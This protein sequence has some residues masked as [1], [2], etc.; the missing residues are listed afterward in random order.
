MSFDELLA[1]EIGRL[2]G[3]LA[4]FAESGQWDDFAKLA[5]K[6]R[7]LSALFEHPELASTAAQLERLARAGD[8]G[9]IPALM[10]RLM[11]LASDALEAD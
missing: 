7:G 11:S 6:L 9:P 1:A 10:T 8:R 3:E 4:I 5:H 2:S